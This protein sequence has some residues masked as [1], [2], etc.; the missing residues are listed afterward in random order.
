M[1]IKTRPYGE[2]EID[3]RQIMEFEHGILGFD[4]V[5][6]FA[7]LDSTDNSPF[8]WLQSLDEPDLAFVIIRPIDFMAEYNLVISS[9]DLEDLGAEVVEDLLVFA[10]VTIPSNPSEMTANLQGPI[11]INAKNRRG[12]Q[13][14][15]QSDKYRVKHGILEEIKKMAADGE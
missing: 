10:I 7:I 8:K 13:A 6:R 2:V 4:F 14:I 12:K 15:S 5:R 11:L 1:K 3:E 9:N